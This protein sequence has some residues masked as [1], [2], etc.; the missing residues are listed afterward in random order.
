MSV[1]AKLS[2]SNF[3]ASEKRLIAIAL[4]LCIFVGAWQLAIKPTFKAKSD[5]RAKYETAIRNY[6]IVQRAVPRLTN[7]SR[8]SLGEQA[9]N[10]TAIIE[11]ARAANIAISRVQPASNDALQVWFD[12]TTS[13]QIYNFLLTLEGDYAVEVTRAQINRRQDGLVSAQFTFT[14]LRVN[15]T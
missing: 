12:E 10:P 3:S 11:T 13:A 5:S 8:S 9:F 1:F 2:P 6:S 14:P 4:P 7:A 15:G